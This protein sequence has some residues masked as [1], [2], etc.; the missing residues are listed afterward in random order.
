MHE[1]ASRPYKPRTVRQ[2]R[3][4]TPPRTD[5][6]TE[7]RFPV[8]YMRKSQPS[9]NESRTMSDLVQLDAIQRMAKANNEPEPVIFADWLKSGARTKLHLRHEYL[10][11]VE[12][13][14][15]GRVTTF[16]G[17]K[18]DRIGRGQTELNRVFDLCE[19][20][21]SLIQ[22]EGLPRLN[23]AVAYDRQMLSMLAM[24]AEA[25]LRAITARNVDVAKSLRQ[26]QYVLGQV[27][28]GKM[29]NPED[30]TKL[31]DDPTEQAG[32]KRIVALYTELR[33]LGATA[34]AL[35]A[36]GVPTRRGAPW[37]GRSVRNILAREA[38]D[39]LP[40]KVERGVKPAAPFRFF[41][42]LQCRCGATLTPSRTFHGRNDTP[43]VRYICGEAIFK[44]GH[45]TPTSITERKLVDWIRTEADRVV[46]NAP[47]VD[48][49]AAADNTAQVALLERRKR[50]IIDNYEDGLIER[51]ERDAK[52]VAIKV[53]LEDLE[54]QSR[55]LEIPPEIDW[56]RWSD[57]D[58]NAVLRRVF[59][60]VKLGDDMLPVRAEL[61][62]KQLA[63][64]PLEPARSAQP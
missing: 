17:Y 11:L 42:L 19:D 13:L 39:V 57:A 53:E 43:Y 30:R 12:L 50:R 56:D 37:S 5:L 8:G 25:E 22:I 9:L 38:P 14:A 34:K 46:A 4:R 1:T 23:P 20:R 27:D 26:K 58:I 7:A 29:V 3:W 24:Q 32:I 52:L 33:S 28:Y 2:D 31:M 55:A 49:Q 41:R 59:A 51:P 16:Y 54:A 45:G 60:Y 6:P 62:S 10:E 47:D 40:A 35:N 64:R 18:I 61:A 21:G 44:E 36:E 48:V 15:E 63:R